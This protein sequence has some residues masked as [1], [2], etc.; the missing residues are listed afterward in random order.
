MVTSPYAIAGR[1]ENPPAN[2][3]AGTRERQRPSTMSGAPVGMPDLRT[4]VWETLAED[5]RTES[6]ALA[7]LQHLKGLVSGVDD[8][9]GGAS[10]AEMFLRT[11]GLPAVL[12]HLRGTLAEDGTRDKSELSCEISQ[13]AGESLLSLLGHADGANA[14]LWTISNI[15]AP[16]LDAMRDAPAIYARTAAGRL[17][18]V[19]AELQPA[20]CGAMV[21]GGLLGLVLSLYDDI[22]NLPG[23]GWDLEFAQDLGIPVADL[24]C[25]LVREGTDAAKELR[26]AILSGKAR[27]GFV[28]L[29]LLQ[30]CHSCSFT[31]ERVRERERGGGREREGEREREREREGEGEKGRLGHGIVQQLVM[32]L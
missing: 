10:R 11:G 30:V 32:G 14:E 5:L 25:T 4:T 17:L 18:F 13:M 21:A 1:R 16:L 22:W 12:P 26:L 19:L 23:G 27:D 6:S 9:R 24:V 28:A 20:E 8:P 2:R 31:S 15:V 29:V 3:P 7:I